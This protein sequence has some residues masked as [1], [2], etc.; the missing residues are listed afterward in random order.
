MA[1]HPNITLWRKGQEAFSRRDMDVVS[2]VFSE[3]VV[4]HFPGTHRFAGDHTGMNSVVQFFVRLISEANVQI[5]EVHSVMAD[6]DHVVAL[7][8]ATANRGDEQLSFDQANI[9]HVAD[10]KITEAWLL[11]ADPFALDDLLS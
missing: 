9:Y 6:D 1:E 10:G 5:T 8:R 2:E 11:P 3:D 4:Y 7:V